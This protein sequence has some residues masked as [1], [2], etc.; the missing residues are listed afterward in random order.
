MPDD[1]KARELSAAERLDWPRLIRSQNA[2]P[3][4]FYELLRHFESAGDALDAIPELSRRGGRKRPLK[5]Q[6]RSEAERELEKTYALGGS[7]VAAIEPN[8]PRALAHI[9]DAPPIITVRGHVHLLEKPTVGKRRPICPRPCGC[10][11][12]GR[13]FLR[14]V[15]PGHRHCRPPGCTF[16][17]HR[18]RHGRRH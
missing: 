5:V 13:I 2:G 4:T 8:Y 18:G 1:L 3:I 12:P 17:W 14:P 11:R 16:E 6:P 10:A 9:P 15:S 7:I